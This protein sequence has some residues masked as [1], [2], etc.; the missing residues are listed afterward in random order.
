MPWV[1]ITASPN[2]SHTS[3]IRMTCNLAPRE[4]NRRKLSRSLESER[5]PASHRFVIIHSSVY[6]LLV[7]QPSNT[8]QLQFPSNPRQCPQADAKTHQLLNN[9]PEPLKSNLHGLHSRGTLA[10]S[11]P[12]SASNS[13]PRR[14]WTNLGAT[15]PE[16][17]NRWRLV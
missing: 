17:K 9:N 11:N 4:Q 8:L 10:K 15:G 13:Q 7:L 1:C 6:Y 2:S 12:R 3:N 16:F 14:G 5:P